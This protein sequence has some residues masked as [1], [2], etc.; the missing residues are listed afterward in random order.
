MH[1]R[2]IALILA[3]LPLAAQA[4]NIS[5]LPL[6][7]P[8]PSDAIPFTSGYTGAAAG[9]GVTRN[10]T[11][12]SL[13]NT[14]GSR[15][16]VPFSGGTLTGPLN[17]PYGGTLTNPV[18]AGPTL[19]G[20]MI[21]S[22]NI[23]ITGAAAAQQFTAWQSSSNPSTL[24]GQSGLHLYNA[25]GSLIGAIGA[26]TANA[27]NLQQLLLTDSGVL[28]GGTTSTPPLLIPVPPSGAVNGLQITAASSGTAPALGA[29]G[30]DANISLA[31]VP[32]GN[33]AIQMQNHI[34]SSGALPTL[35]AC[36]TS[37]S[38]T[39]GSTDTR[40]AITEGTT[41]TGCTI[42]FATAYA[43]APV[44]VVSSPNGIL[45]TSYSA[46]TTALTIANASATGDQFTYACM[47]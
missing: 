10:M 45:P 23:N 39:T 44:C 47:Q 9:S 14:P 24:Y 40:G 3:L 35:S 46:S 13:L 31:I 20:T 27:A 29:Q 4:Q 25:S 6:A 30:G 15:L 5:T 33:G 28:I 32:K 22:G 42:A 38:I 12:Q 26:N 37:P 1:N 43:T 2:T 7:T 8:L 17:M 16:Y 18:L 34:A 36:G 41:A 11:V 19:T 21:G